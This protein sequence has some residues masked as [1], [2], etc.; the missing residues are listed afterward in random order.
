MLSVFVC[1]C[2]CVCEREREREREHIGAYLGVKVR[3]EA[4]IN[5]TIAVIGLIQAAFLAIL[6]SQKRLLCQY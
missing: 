3:L 4:M 1:V 2:V 5:H 6:S